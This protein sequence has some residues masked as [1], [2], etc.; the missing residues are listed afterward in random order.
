MKSGKS[1]KVKV[2]LTRGRQEGQVPQAEAQGDDRADRRHRGKD[3][4]HPAEAGTE[5]MRARAKISASVTVLAATAMMLVPAVAGAG[6][7]S[8]SFEDLRFAA[9]PG[10]TNNLTVSLDGANF[11]LDD[12]GAPITPMFGCVAVNANRASCP[13]AAVVGRLDIS[14]NDLNDVV[15]IEASV[16]ELPST[17]LIQG[18]DGNDSITSLST[19]GLRAFGGSGNDSLV[20]GPNRDDLDGNDGNDVMVGNGGND[21]LTPGPGTD[22][23]NGGP[24]FDQLDEGSTSNGADTFLGGPDSDE[25]NYRGRVNSVRV[26]LDGVA[27]DGE[28]AEGD[29]IGSD[30]EDVHGGKGGDTLAGNGSDNEI[31]GN[32]GGD[33]IAGGGGADDLNG[34]DRADTITGGAGDDQI[35]GN[36][37]ADSLSGEGG[38]DSFRFEFRDGDPDQISGGDGLDSYRD[39]SALGMQIDLDGNADDGYRDPLEGPANDNV[40]ADVENLNASENQPTDDAL[41]GNDAANQIEGGA[42]NDQI[43]GLGGPDALFG[44][45]GDDKIDGG[46][47]VDTLDGAGGSDQIRSRD[48]DSDEVSCGSSNDTLLA[49]SFDDFSVTCDQASTGAILKSGFAKLNRKKKAKVKVSCPAAEGITCKVKI[50]AKK[51]KKTLA[52]GSGKVKSG[53][54][55]KV[56]VKLTRAGKKVRSRKLK[57]KATTVL[58][59]ATGAK[60]ATIRPKLVLRR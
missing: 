58:T 14:L 46:T 52:K 57:L 19:Y 32:G 56:K 17:A 37:G 50:T 53:K 48:F 35:Q 5:A 34:G 45:P 44:G 3:S 1:G 22:V 13:A 23:A 20:G 40:G 59:D 36:D 41:T 9:A 25:V 15:L 55:G 42:G 6:S 38:S 8:I 29:N 2:K 27:D 43:N 21:N 18:G 51:G 7:A 30:V 11:V 49:D 24:G 26:T 33:T 28:L 54:S 12:T 31:D 16:P 47:G 4:D 10:E 60:T 39:G